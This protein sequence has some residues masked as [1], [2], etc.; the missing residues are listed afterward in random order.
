MPAPFASWF[1]NPV[2][3]LERGTRPLWRYVLRATFPAW[4]LVAA[5]PIV[6][7]FVIGLQQTPGAGRA[8]WAIAAGGW[9]LMF[10]YPVWA[11][12][13]AVLEWEK[14][15]Q[16]Q[17]IRMTPLPPGDVA[18]GLALVAGVRCAAVMIAL[19]GGFIVT[20]ALLTVMTA[21]RGGGIDIGGLIGLSLAAVLQVLVYI[22]IVMAPN[23]LFGQWAAL[24]WRGTAAPRLVLVMTALAAEL[25]M[26][27]IYPPGYVP[28]KIF[29]GWLAWREIQALLQ[30]LKDK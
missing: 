26:M 29:L 22:P 9:A 19:I 30:R 15:G 11:G 24:R 17:A 23:I 25:P 7:G 2:Y 13:G 5:V 1:D 21:A 20:G 4:A 28:V 16:M 27:M 8:F 3:R 14:S 6:I 18:M 10:V 12:G